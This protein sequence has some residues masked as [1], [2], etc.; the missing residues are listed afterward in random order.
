MTTTISIVFGLE[1]CKCEVNTEIVFNGGMIQK[2]EGTM[3]PPP[4][5]TLDSNQTHH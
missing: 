4:H 2:I 3:S 5:P 1:S